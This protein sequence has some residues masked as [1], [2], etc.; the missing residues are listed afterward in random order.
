MQ[1]ECVFLGRLACDC[2]CS[3]WSFPPCQAPPTSD[4]EE[5]WWAARC[6]TPSSWSRVLLGSLMEQGHSL[7]PDWVSQP[8]LASSGLSGCSGLGM[9]TFRGD[10]RE[11]VPT[12]LFFLDHWGLQ[13]VMAQNWA[14]GPELSC[15][16]L[17]LS[18]LID[19]F[20]YSFPYAVGL[21]LLIMASALGWRA[22]VAG[23]S[24]SV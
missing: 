5:A 4:S 23:S 14:C 13:L 12:P 19:V 3:A 24:V 7:F 1:P 2:L 8:S 6:P 18:A 15:S 17:S 20:V 10:W 22:T 11:V 21:C 9:A 16:Y